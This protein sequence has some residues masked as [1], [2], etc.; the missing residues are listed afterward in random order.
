MGWDWFVNSYLVMLT[1]VRVS[2]LVAG[3]R[4]EEVKR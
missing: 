1:A 2:V 3:R 4:E